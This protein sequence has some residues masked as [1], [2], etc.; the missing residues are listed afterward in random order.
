[1]GSVIDVTVDDHGIAY[2][3]M[4][5]TEGKNIFS[6]ILAGMILMKVSNL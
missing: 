3:H 6:A 2:F 1:M 4:N 5:D